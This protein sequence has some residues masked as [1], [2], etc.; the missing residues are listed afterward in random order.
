MAEKGLAMHCH[1]RKS[2]QS[3]RQGVPWPHRLDGSTTA[4]TWLT[5]HAYGQNISTLRAHGIASRHRQRQKKPRD[6]VTRVATLAAWPL[7]GPHGTPGNALCHR[8]VLARTAEATE[9]DRLHDRKQKTS[10]APLSAASSSTQ[11]CG[12]SC[13]PRKISD[14]DSR[15]CVLKSTRLDPST[16]HSCT[17]PHSG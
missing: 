3:L 9:R 6:A 1:E 2:A 10:P 11:S 17:A 13:D 7:H 5:R 8:E 4:S 16:A 12:S 14:D 15:T